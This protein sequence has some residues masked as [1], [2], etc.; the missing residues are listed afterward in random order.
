MLTRRT[1]IQSASTLAAGA[2]TGGGVFPNGE[3]KAEGSKG[4]P[5][6]VDLLNPDNVKPTSEEMLS[7]LYWS[8]HRE[9]ERGH[10]TENEQWFRM[11]LAALNRSHEEAIHLGSFVARNMF[12]RLPPEDLTRLR[13]VLYHPTEETWDNAY[14]IILNPHVVLGLGLWQAV[15]AVDP[16]FPQVGPGTDSM[17]RKV[18]RW[19]RIPS[20]ALLRAALQ[21]ATH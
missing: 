5:I 17:G 11:V 1:F 7:F 12:G 15:I 3:M 9:K 2:A 6:T 4:E 13:A 18:G 19:R 8:E 14:S 10:N 21:Y 16:S 20:K